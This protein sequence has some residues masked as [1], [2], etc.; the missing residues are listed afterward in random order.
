MLAIRHRPLSAMP[1]F[2]AVRHCHHRPPFRRQARHA[3]IASLRRSCRPLFVNVGHCRHCHSRF[4][5]SF[6]TCGVIWLK[7]ST[8]IDDGRPIDDA[9][10]HK[11]YKRKRYSK[12][13]KDPPCTCSQ[14]PVNTSPSPCNI[15]KR[16]SCTPLYKYASAFISPLHIHVRSP[17][18]RHHPTRS[19]HAHQAPASL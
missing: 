16:S 13:R 12:K 1:P 14:A 7:I 10:I 2:F 17:V 15:P 9:C 18:A 3:A 6:C 4:R 11:R 8:A 5:F 19:Q